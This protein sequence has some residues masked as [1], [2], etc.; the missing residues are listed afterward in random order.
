LG[1]R[2]ERRLDEEAHLNLARRWFCRLGLAGDVPDHSAFSK[3][4]HGRFRDSDGLCELFEATVARCMAEGLVGGEDFAVGASLIKADANRQRSMPG[5]QGSARRRDD[6]L[7]GGFYPPERVEA[8]YPDAIERMRKQR[9]S[10]RA[11]DQRAGTLPLSQSRSSV[12]AGRRGGIRRLPPASTGQGPA[13]APQRRTTLRARTA[14]RHV[15]GRSPQQLQR[16]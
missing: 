1:I 3:N 11:W 8:E 15:V 13:A 2:S 9:Q 7:R 10:I 6:M 4:R 5:K 12:R 14:I 16:H